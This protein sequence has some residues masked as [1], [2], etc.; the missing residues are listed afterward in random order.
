MVPTIVCTIGLVFLLS[1]CHQNPKK[2]LFEFV[3]TDRSHLDFANTITE[4][5]SVNPSECLN[6]F[7][8]GG[9][10]IG[11]FNNDGLSDIV[12]TGNQ[13]SSAL[14]LNMGSL[15]F[16]DVSAEANFSTNSW[17]TGVSIVDINADGFDDI[18]LNVAGVNCENNCHNLLFI[19]Q[20][21]N[22]A[23]IPNF[24]EQAEVYGLDDGNML[25]SLFFLTMIK[26]E[27]LMFISFIIRTI[28]ILAGI[29]QDL[30]NTGPNTSQIIC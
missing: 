22:E 7:N 30:N 25:H 24:L 2:N 1:S 4:N 8:G 18:Y 20:G 29:R 14:Y 15:V 10:G 11:D 9:V 16:E 26:T 23:G 3:D 28:Q 17:I 12:F 21:L 27:I 6:C 13:V 5:D 19:N